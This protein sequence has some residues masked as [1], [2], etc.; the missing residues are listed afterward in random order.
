MEIV[1]LPARPLRRQFIA[2]SVCALALCV[3]ALAGLAKYSQYGHGA[4]PH[5]YLAKAVK[6]AGD[7]G[8]IAILAIPPI[9][10]QFSR[11]EP[12]AHLIVARFEPVLPEFAVSDSF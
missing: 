8:K 6:M 12:C 10:P 11:P 9:V 4:H 2:V 5:G 3:A 7:R 1:V